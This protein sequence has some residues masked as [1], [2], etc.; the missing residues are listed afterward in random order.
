M[1]AFGKLFAAARPH[2]LQLG[3]L[4][5]LVLDMDG[6]AEVVQGSQWPFIYW[7]NRSKE[8]PRPDEYLPGAGY[9]RA[10]EWVQRTSKNVSERGVAVGKRSFMLS[11]SAG[12]RNCV[13][14]P[15]ALRMIPTLLAVLLRTFEFEL[16]DPAY[17]LKLG[18]LY[19]TWVTC[20]SNT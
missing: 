13:G 3:I 8:L 20:V 14:Q 2:L 6:E 12:A 5:G 10:G 4:T 7:I 17:E 1:L 15:L 18:K 11:F 19:S 16:A 9:K